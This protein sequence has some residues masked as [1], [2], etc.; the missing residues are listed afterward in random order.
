MICPK[1]I[2]LHEVV[3]YMPEAMTMPLHQPEASEK[4]HNSQNFI[5]TIIMAVKIASIVSGVARRGQGGT[6]V[7]GRR[8]E[9]APK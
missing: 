5:A 7:P 6:Y 9:G 4:C 8:V 1:K 2:K 3:I